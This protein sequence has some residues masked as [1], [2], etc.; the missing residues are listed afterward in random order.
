MSTQ[1]TS[2]TGRSNLFPPE[3]D[4]CTVPADIKER[5]IEDRDLHDAAAAK[6]S[7]SIAA[8]RD[9]ASY[10]AAL[11]DK[12]RLVLSTNRGELSRLQQELQQEIART[13]WQQQS[14]GAIGAPLPMTGPHAYAGQLTPSELMPPPPPPQQPY[15]QNKLLGPPA[16]QAVAAFS[17]APMMEGSWLYPAD[18][19]QSTTDMSGI[20][21]LPDVYT[22]TNTPLIDAQPD[23]S[24][25][26][27]EYGISPAALSF[28]E[29]TAFVTTY[30]NMNMTH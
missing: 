20:Q 5:G 9:R 30:Q 12:Q 15:H 7:A 26:A 17:Q 14:H 3:V 13:P 21:G 4:L 11:V 16:D 19:M 10:L 6:L 8:A 23:G 29:A 2:Q 1:E 18:F 25:H 27:S 28:E 24:N 22:P